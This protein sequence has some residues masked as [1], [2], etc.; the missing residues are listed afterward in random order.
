MVEPGSSSADS[1]WKV[2]RNPVKV[3]RTR[4]RTRTQVGSPVPCS[5]LPRPSEQK[6]YE[7]TSGKNFLK[8]LKVSKA[9]GELEQKAEDRTLQTLR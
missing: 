6:Q 2:D 7:E 1:T 3:S 8:F 9:S 5:S 4:T